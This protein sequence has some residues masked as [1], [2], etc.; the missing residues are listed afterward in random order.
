MHVFEAAAN[1]GRAVLT[2]QSTSVH[3]LALRTVYV[4]GTMH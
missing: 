3:L 4:F 2:G 1:R